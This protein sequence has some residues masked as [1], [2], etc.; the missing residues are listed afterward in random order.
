M[1]KD[2]KDIVAALDV[3]VDDSKLKKGPKGTYISWSDSADILTSIFGT[4]GWEESIEDVKFDSTNGIYAVT[5][6]I[7][8][9]A[10]EYDDEGKP[11]RVVSITRCGV[12]RAVAGLDRNGVLQH[13]GAIASADSDSF[14]RAAKKFGNALGL[15]LYDKDD[16][17][18]QGTS[19]FA[20]AP[21]STPAA[22]PGGLNDKRP[23]DKQANI[24]LTKMGYTPEQ[25]AA[26]PFQTWKA[27][28]D[29]Y[30]A[31]RAS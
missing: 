25:L 21:R 26:T 1:Y 31:S 28:I 5:R 8:G 3:R 14:S 13:D 20:A 27:D 29:E 18:N 19:A 6:T 17:A 10:Q 22:A 9:F 12:G 16:P 11:F 7:T 15:F 30:F 4:E 23:S 24:L 2:L